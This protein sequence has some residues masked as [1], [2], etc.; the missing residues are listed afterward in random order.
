[1]REQTT[2]R[3]WRKLIFRKCRKKCRKVVMCFVNRVR[4]ENPTGV[5]FEK[6]VNEQRHKA[7]RLYIHT[8]VD[9]LWHKSDV[10]EKFKVFNEL[11]ENKFGRMM[12][13]LRSDNGGSIKTKISTVISSNVG[14]N[15]KTQRRI[16][17]SRTVRQKETKRRLWG[18]REPCCMGKISRL[19][20][21]RKQ[22]AWPCI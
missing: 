14:F 8:Y 6:S 20:Y 10:Y 15:V 13:V 4:S 12:R 1:M 21:G 3:T 16:R 2:R 11:I 22:Q 18:A 9:F 17:R 19:H 5:R 7:V